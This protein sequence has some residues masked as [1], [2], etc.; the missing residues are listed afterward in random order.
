MIVLIDLFDLVRLSLSLLHQN[1]KD[2]RSGVLL[3]LMRAYGSTTHV[4]RACGSHFPL[5]DRRACSPGRERGNI[6][7][8]R[9][10]PLVFN[11]SDLRCHICAYI[12]GDR[13]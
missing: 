2:T 11:S 8:V 4:K 10:N 5:E 13:A 6:D 3:I 12:G 9:Q 1:Q 7:A